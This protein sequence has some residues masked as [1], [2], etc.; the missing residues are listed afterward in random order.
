MGHSSRGYLC[1]TRLRSEFALTSAHTARFSPVK[2]VHADG[3]S[4]ETASVHLM[5][6][7][8]LDAVLDD[9]PESVVKSEYPP[10][11]EQVRPLGFEPRTCGLR[12]P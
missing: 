7:I 11:S 12:G 6:F 5:V 9:G 8:S 2:H 1:R 4:V 3:R 10:S